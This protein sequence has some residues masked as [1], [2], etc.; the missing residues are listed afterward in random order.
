MKG[1]GS[2]GAWASLIIGF[3]GGAGLSLTLMGVLISWFVNLFPLGGP[4][5]VAIGTVIIAVDIW[6]D[7]KP[8]GPAILAAILMPSAALGT[9]GVWGEAIRG[10]ATGVAVPINQ[11]MSHYVGAASMWAIA[12]VA[13]FTTLYIQKKA[14]GFLGRLL[15]LPGGGSRGG[16]RMPAGLGH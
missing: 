5:L 16:V 2:G 7:K 13:I 3:I 1:K 11:S 10:W 15:P 14:G 8:D 9:G 6:H 4:V 12:A